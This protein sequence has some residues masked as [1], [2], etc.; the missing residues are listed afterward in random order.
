MSIDGYSVD[1]TQRSD[2]VR[3]H[4]EAPIECGFLIKLNLL[5]C[6][7]EQLSVFGFSI[8]VKVPGD[9]SESGKLILKKVYFDPH[10][11]LRLQ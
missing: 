4:P 3:A 1:R 8:F 9:D 11:S 7:I 2:V 5:K 10:F 6:S